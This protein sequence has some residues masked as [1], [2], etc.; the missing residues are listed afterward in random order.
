MCGLKYNELFGNYFILSR[1]FMQQDF[2]SDASVWLNVTV[3]AFVFT[4][5]ANLDECD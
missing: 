5:Y 2:R 4:H 3:H 1:R